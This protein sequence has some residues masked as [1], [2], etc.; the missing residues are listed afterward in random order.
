MDHTKT[1]TKLYGKFV[2]DEKFAPKPKTT[3]QKSINHPSHAL[4]TT[5]ADT[6]ENTTPEYG[7]NKSTNQIRIC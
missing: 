2:L 3:N 4:P 6:E 1:N 5:S 7:P